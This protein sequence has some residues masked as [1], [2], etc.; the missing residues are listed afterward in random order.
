MIGLLP[1]ASGLLGLDGRS[2][3]VWAGASIHEV[4]Q[5]VAAGGAIGG[6]ALAVAVVVKLA[7]VLMLAPVLAWVG[8]RRRRQ[9]V[10]QG[11]TGSLPPLVP[12][13]VAGFIALVL[14]YTWVP[15][16]GTVLELAKIAQ[17][18]LLAAAMFA[19]GCGVRIGQLRRAGARPALLATLAT[20]WVAAIG[21]TGTL[22]LAR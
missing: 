15:L 9:L 22:L 13:F 3:G 8:W 16:P 17:T 14:V 10:Q 7:R 20:G 19:L 6:G 5:V 12:G 21:L 2:G 18:A 1:L 11:S 4:A